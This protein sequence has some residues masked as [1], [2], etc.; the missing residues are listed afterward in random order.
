MKTERTRIR[1]RMMRTGGKRAGGKI[2]GNREQ[3]AQ[4]VSGVNM[5]NGNARIDLKDFSGKCR[6][7]PSAGCMGGSGLSESAC[8]RRYERIH[9]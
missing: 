8:D 9:F 1:N 7:V 4:R 2:S 6:Y 5:L 3:R